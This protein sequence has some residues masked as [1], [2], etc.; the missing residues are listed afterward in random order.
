LQGEFDWDAETQGLILGAFYYGHAL[1]Q[2]FGGML[3]ERYGGKWLMAGG[4]TFGSVTTMFFPPIARYSKELFIAVRVIQGAVEGILYPAYFT[5]ASKW[6]PKPE[7]AF[8]S[9]IVLT[10]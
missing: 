2:P 8:L 6:L 7:K 1:I 4:L 9:S 10:G 3:A 5:M